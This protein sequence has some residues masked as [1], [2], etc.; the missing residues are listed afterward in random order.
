MGAKLSVPDDSPIIPVKKLLG[1]VYRDI[2]GTL[3]GAPQ[4]PTSGNGKI[5]VPGDKEFWQEI[6]KKYV[7]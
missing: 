6:E 7:P 2:Y 3:C 5:N 4:K 1:E